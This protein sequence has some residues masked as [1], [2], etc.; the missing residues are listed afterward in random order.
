MEGPLPPPLR[1]YP[2]K[3]LQLIILNT[4]KLSSEQAASSGAGA[5]SAINATGSVTAND[6]ST[7]GV[8][9]IDLKAQSDVV[10]TQANAP[11]TSNSL[12]LAIE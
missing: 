4:Y 6:G 10:L 11:T 7:S 9:P 5:A 2:F 1:E 3:H 12:G 8:S